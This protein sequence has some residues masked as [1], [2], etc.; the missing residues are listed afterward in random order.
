VGGS[1]DY[2]ISGILANWEYDPEDSIRIIKAS[3]GRD[4][5]QVRQPLGIEQYELDGRPDGEMPY[6]KETYLD[7][8][9]ERINQFKEDSE[10]D[11]GFF[12]QYEDFL[13]LQNEGILFYYRYLILFQIGDFKRTVRDTD[14]NLKLCEIIEKYVED[15]NVKKEILQYKPYILRIN[16]IARA[17]LSLKKEL[18]AVA[19]KIIES[20]IEVIQKMPDVDTTSYQFEKIRSIHSLKATLKQI[21][22]QKPSPVDRLELELERAVDAEEYEKA[23]EL[24]DK[25]EELENKING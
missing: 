10:S 6:G 12:I 4:I 21:K 1:V 14:H 17:M 23:A 19:V 2:D 8:Y 7:V 16:A 5:L 11:E 20:A 3:D 22:K 15:N 9:L 18:Q 24:R 25:I 13:K